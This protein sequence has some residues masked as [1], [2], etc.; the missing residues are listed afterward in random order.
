[1][2]SVMKKILTMVLVVAIPLI[3]FANIIVSVN[4]TG[5]YSKTATVISIATIQ[6][7]NVPLPSTFGQ[8]IAPFYTIQGSNVIL[9]EYMKVTGVSSSAV[10]VVR[11]VNGSNAVSIDGSLVHYLSIN[12]AGTA[13]ATMTPTGTSTATSTPTNTATASPS[14]TPTNTP[15]NTTTNTATTTPTPTFTNT[16]TPTVTPNHGSGSGAGN[17]PVTL[18]VF[19]GPNDVIMVAYSSP[20]TGTLSP[21]AVKANSSPTPNII[22]QPAIT[23]GTTGVWNFVWHVITQPNTANP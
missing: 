14:N 6:V 17:V 18:A 9:S 19:N 13:T 21:L 2:N 20:A 23:P 3:V 1:M 5:S 22:I 10:T 8:Y 4:S 11:G 15:T 7:T 16:V 12:V